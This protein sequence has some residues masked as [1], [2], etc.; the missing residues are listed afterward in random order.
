MKSVRSRY[1]DIHKKLKKPEEESSSDENSNDIPDIKIF[2][3]VDLYNNDPINITGRPKKMKK[4]EKQISS[5]N[6]MR[7]SNALAIASSRG[8]I[9][10]TKTSWKMDDIFLGF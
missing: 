10:K 4:N 1:S 9:N 5:M 2:D 8:N 7:K 6:N 3:D